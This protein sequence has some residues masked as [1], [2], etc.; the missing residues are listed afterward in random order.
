MII[1]KRQ[2]KTRPVCLFLSFKFF[3]DELYLKI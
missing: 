2:K 1:N 3:S